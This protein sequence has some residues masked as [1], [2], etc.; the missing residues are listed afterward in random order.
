MGLHD[1][2]KDSESSKSTPSSSPPSLSSSSGSS[3]AHACS[4]EGLTKEPSVHVTNRRCV[5]HSKTAKDCN[6]AFKYFGNYS[7]ESKP[8][9]CNKESVKPLCT[10]NTRHRFSVTDRAQVQ[11]HKGICNKKSPV[12]LGCPDPKF[13][14]IRNK[15]RW[16]KFHSIEELEN[17]LPNVIVETSWHG[18]TFCFIKCTQGKDE[19]TQA[20]FFPPVIKRQSNRSRERRNINVNIVLED[21]ISRSQ[22]YRYLPRSVKVLQQIANDP[23]SKAT[24]LDY[25]LVQSYASFTLPN[26]QYLM[27]GTK[28]QGSHNRTS[29]IDVLA[30]KFKSLGY[31]TLFQEDLCW[32]D[33]WGSLLSPTYKQK[34]RYFTKDFQQ[35]FEK[36]IRST[37]P[38]LDDRGLSLF[39]CEALKSLGYTNPFKG[40]K[41][42]QLCWEGRFF[43]DYFLTYV[44]KFLSAIEQ[45]PRAAPALVYTHLN[46]AHE[47]TGVRVRTDDGVLS[48]FF[49][50]MVRSENTLTIVLSDHGAKTNDYAIKSL[51]GS[52]EV[53]S[54]MLFMIIPENV[55]LKLGKKRMD[56]LLANQKRLVS[57]LDLHRMLI[58]LGDL[59]TPV[60]DDSRLSGLLAPVPLSRT[61]ADVEGLGSDA[62]CRCQGWHEFLSESSSE[63]IWLAEYA[64]GEL[65]NMI[66]KQYT[67]GEKS[68]RR[69]PAYGA[70]A[71]FVGKRVERPRRE[72]VGE[73]Y[74]I[75][76]VLVVEPAYGVESTERF[77]VQLKY[78]S[79]HQHNVTFVKFNRLSFYSKYE[80]CADENVD[81]KLCACAM[82]ASAQALET[83]DL[84]QRKNFNL[85]TTVQSLDSRCLFLAVRKLNMKVVSKVQTRVMA[86][87]VANACKHSV[88][89]LDVAGIYKMARI[90]RT[91]PFTVRI[92]PRSVQ[93][94]FSVYND[95]KYGKFRPVINYAPVFTR[96]REKETN[97]GKK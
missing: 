8:P 7:L 87:E 26:A 33:Y 1:N 54:P 4:Y 2:V 37:K 31:Q 49:T 64:L 10:F 82:D 74:V 73:N 69:R 97:L 77:E 51:A 85:K 65:N 36:Y 53:Y 91:L 11:C 61:C 63:V 88:F 58:S 94:L 71:R 30:Q 78:S 39:T 14:T 29:G 18:F 59:Q 44:W 17:E 66:Q 46:T 75:T 41:L 15:K 34:L 76:L 93:F 67:E 60:V 92:G 89:T 35:A 16:Q 56:A 42:P 24:V 48:Q 32:H 57:V 72:L 13:G 3:T 23:T 84:I 40:D 27:A 90:S 19:S 9:K 25:E 95:W 55:A 43:S 45:V 38:H 70:C 12:F 22:F 20:L 83:N 52:L 86:V 47:T 79:L 62:I 50:E 5:P 81:V 21:S 6:E 68:K 80:S 96:T 28:Y